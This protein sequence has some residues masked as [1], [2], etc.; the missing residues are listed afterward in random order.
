MTDIMTLNTQFVMSDTKNSAYFRGT[1]RFVA[2]RVDS[3]KALGEAQMSVVAQKCQ[4]ID[5]MNGT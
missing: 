2:S 4:K 3:I 5:C 1:A